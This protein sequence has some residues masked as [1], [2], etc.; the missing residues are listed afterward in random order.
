MAAVNDVA[1]EDF[2][3]NSAGREAFGRKEFRN[4][5]EKG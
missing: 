1:L 4:L 2:E 3:V 5:R